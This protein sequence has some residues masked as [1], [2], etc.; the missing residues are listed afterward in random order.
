M[1]Y[2]ELNGQIIPIPYQR[3]EDCMAECRR[4]QETMV[5]I[6]VCPVFV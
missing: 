2:V 6:C 1:W 5:A 4:L 3:Y